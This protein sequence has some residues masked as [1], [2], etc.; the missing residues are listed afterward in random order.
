VARSRV[1]FTFTRQTTLPEH[2]RT[3]TDQWSPVPLCPQHRAVQHHCTTPI[4]FTPYFEV[5]STPYGDL[6]RNG[7]VNQQFSPSD[8]NARS[9]NPLSVI[10]TPPPKHTPLRSCTK[11]HVEKCK[12]ASTRGYVVI[13]HRDEKRTLVWRHIRIQPRVQVLPPNC[14]T[15]GVT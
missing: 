8:R 4:W 15:N 12:K 10:T 1:A 9:N 2:T 11:I 7:I 13:C 5:W 6:S 3:A 14:D